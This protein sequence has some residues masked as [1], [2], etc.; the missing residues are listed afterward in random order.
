MRFEV[1]ISVT[2]F[3]EALMK[4]LKA[5]TALLTVF[6]ASQATADPTLMFG[7]SFNF[8]GGAPASTGLT[9]KLLSDNKADSVVG[10]AGFSY[11]FD[12]DGYFG[13]DAG[14]GYLFDGNVA[15]TLTYDFLNQR[16]QVSLGYAD[17]C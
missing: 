6:L 3:K 7:L 10:A 13:F 4:N 12:N 8:G 1:T 5:S 16:P 2:N 11:F 9:V 15:T 14:L 17:V